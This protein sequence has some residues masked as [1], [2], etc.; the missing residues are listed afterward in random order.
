MG[1]VPTNP[2]PG[3]PLLQATWL[4]EG[5]TESVDSIKGHG[6]IEGNGGEPSQDCPAGIYSG[7]YKG[8]L[9]LER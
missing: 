9:K 7:S 3:G 4:L 8:S 6:T 2:P 1:T 5:L